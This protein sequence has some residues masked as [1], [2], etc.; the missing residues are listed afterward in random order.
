[1]SKQGLE[2][3]VIERDDIPR[4]LLVAHNEDLVG[5]IEQILTRANGNP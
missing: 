4:G 3:V 5:L 2:Y 1:M